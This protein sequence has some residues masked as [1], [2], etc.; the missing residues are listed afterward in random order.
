[1]PREIIMDVV[2]VRQVVTYCSDQDGQVLA[3]YHGYTVRVGDRTGVLYFDRT[4]HVG[5][6]KPHQVTVDFSSASFYGAASD[7]CQDIIN[8]LPFQPLPN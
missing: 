5:S 4:Y 1:L 7:A 8:R 3:A 2:S 6:G